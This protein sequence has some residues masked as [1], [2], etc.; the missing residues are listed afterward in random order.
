MGEIMKEFLELMKEVF[1]IHG[2]DVRTDELFDFLAVNQRE[3]LGV[4][5]LE[6]IDSKDLS[7]IRKLNGKILLITPRRIPEKVKEE[8]ERAVYEIWDRERLEREIGKAIIKEL[9]GEEESE[10]RGGFV[11]LCVSEED[12]MWI[13]R[14]FFGRC[15]G[16][17]LRYLP[18][19]V[20]EY[21]VRGLREQDGELI[22]ISGSGEGALNA[23]TGEN[24]WISLKN[25]ERTEEAEGE[26][27]QPEIDYE[28][29]VK[30][31]KKRIKER[32][33][34]RK[35]FKRIVRESLISE[36]KKFYP[37][38]GEIELKMELLYIPVWEV[39]SRDRRVELNGYN[40]EP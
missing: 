24:Y 30:E 25:V 14:S 32:H 37:E 20:Y 19:W 10:E 11:K 40:G 17:H 27:L 7:R 13:C 12:A 34:V 3:E 22:R 31:V 23:V 9:F 35:S 5:V 39:R 26:M 2:Y 1:R 4:I 21:D 29:A 16:A 15:D 36:V 18:F 33:V 28:E 6:R 8:L 38:D